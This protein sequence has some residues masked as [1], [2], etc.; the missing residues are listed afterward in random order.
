MTARDEHDGARCGGTTD[1]SSLS[2][3]HADGAAEVG[4]SLSARQ[5]DGAA[6]LV[7]V[8]AAAVAKLLL[9]RFIAEGRDVIRRLPV[10]KEF[11]HLQRSQQQACRSGAGTMRPRLGGQDPMILHFH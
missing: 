2:V 10:R 4:N 1:R 7:E 9:V 8:D 3:R 5:A 6:M 11:R